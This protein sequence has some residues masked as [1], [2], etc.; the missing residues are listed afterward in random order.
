[1]PYIVGIDT[2]GTFTGGAG[3]LGSEGDRGA[4]ARL[5]PGEA[6]NSGSQAGARRG[7][8]YVAH[9]HRAA[10]EPREQRLSILCA[11]LRLTASVPSAK[12]RTYI[13]PGGITHGFR[14]IGAV[15]DERDC[16]RR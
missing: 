6:S 10:R 8:P 4:D 7:R 15:L 2:G 3:W 11:R 16:H 13:A 14:E 9:P 12:E 5:R 1:M